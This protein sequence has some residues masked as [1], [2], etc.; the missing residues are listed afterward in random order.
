[1]TKLRI[2]AVSINTT[3][4]DINGNFE[5]IKSAI[6]S[7]E[8][9]DSDI[10]V[11]PE[12]SIT[13]YGCE[14]AFFKSYLWDRALASLE[15]IQNIPTEKL[16]L[17]GLPVYS[18]GFLYNCMAVILDGK[19]KAFV[20][21]MHLANTGVHYETRWFHS[22]PRFLNRTIH[23]NDHTIPFGNFIFQYKEF[24]FA[25][26]I[27]EDSWNHLKPSLTYA[28]QG[29]DIL[30][31]PGASHFA[32]GKQNVRKRIFL[33]TSR[34]QNNLIVYTNLNGNESGRIIFEGGSLFCESGNLVRE[35]KRLFYSDYSI[36]NHTTSLELIRSK[37]A[38]EFR[39]SKQNLNPIT[40]IV[41]EPRSKKSFTVTDKR[42]SNTSSSE[43]SNLGL[44][45]YEEFTKAVSLGLFDYLRKSKT[46]GFT[47]S[48]SG[49]A[50]SAICALLVDA[51]KNQ[52]KLERGANC[53]SK[54]GIDEKNLLVTIYQKT[55][56]NSK[57]TEQIAALLSEELQVPHHSISIDNVVKTSV[58]LIEN[59][60]QRKLD[61]KTDDLALQNI[62]ARVRS[63]L[64]WLLANL[65]GH[66]LISTGNRSEASVGYTTMDGDSSG[67]VCP[68]SGVSKEFL[69]EFLDD[70]QSGN[71]RFI[72]PKESIRLLRETKPTAE[73]RPLSEHQEDEKDLMPYPILQKIEE[74]IV[75]YGLS[76]NETKQRL[77]EAFPK[78]SESSILSKVDR[79]KKL[80][81]SAQWKRERLPPGFHLDE[82][83]I[84]PKSSYRFP[85]LSNES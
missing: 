63:P 68:I 25:I 44:S 70:I 61:W 81:M 76:E 27:C 34:S 57:I 35:G 39:S 40:R 58:D 55:V 41:L 74:C 62:Q 77:S 19:I 5:I 18:D 17:V 82:Y 49:G 79:F 22:E 11:F 1:M 53:F 78:E 12:L 66:L 50:D 8:C 28:E 45:K 72:T 64:V 71:N 26:E 24:S 29:I 65:N 15:K 73:L 16:V 6:L 43:L 21:K 60:I 23:L 38:K 47:L 33:E 10:I 30:F 36:T 80:F 14:D 69:L 37:R 46:K 3:P 52:A 84:D 54:M 85:I 4:L 9:L 51:M 67:S 2:S 75:H 31:S 7:S 83:G 48:L 20:P 42:E 13:G 59:T 32:F 56:N